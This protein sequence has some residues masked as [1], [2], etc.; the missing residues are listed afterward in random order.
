M[1]K[2]SEDWCHLA[3]A[4]KGAVV[5]RRGCSLAMYSLEM[6][7]FCDA[8]IRDWQE[9][10]LMG[11]LC[12]NHCELLSPLGCFKSANHMLRSLVQPCCGLSLA[13]LFH[14]ASEVP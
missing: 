3:P 6:F 1:K 12:E 10:I 5:E 14:L 11:V 8:D 7:P 13:W 2:V 9:L 4:S